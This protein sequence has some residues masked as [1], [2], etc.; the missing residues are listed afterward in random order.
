LAASG[1]LQTRASI[2]I[3]ASQRLLCGNRIGLFRPLRIPVGRNQ[4]RRNLLDRIP[5]H[6]P[7]SM[8]RCDYRQRRQTQQ[9]W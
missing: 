4:P 9:Q 3:V 5:L 6:Q 1:V 7:Y 2:N 8:L